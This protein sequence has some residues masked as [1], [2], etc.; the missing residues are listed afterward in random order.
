MHRQKHGRSK[1][2]RR[3]KDDKELEA[4]DAES[5]LKCF[6]R[7]RGAAQAFDGATGVGSSKGVRGVCSKSNWFEFN[8]GVSTRGIAEPVY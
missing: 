6:G 2:V 4:D 7:S 1:V 5:V 8:A 3:S